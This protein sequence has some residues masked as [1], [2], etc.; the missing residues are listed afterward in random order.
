L[1]VFQESDTGLRQFGSLRNTTKQ[2][3]PDFVFQI[4]NL[5]AE[6]RLTDANTSGGAS[7]IPLFRNGKK[8][9]DVSK[10]QG[11]SPKAIKMTTIIY[12][13]NSASESTL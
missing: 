3:G 9:A 13:K 5:Q 6:R 12:W 2:R 7:E 11:P 10:F 1:D 4:S 8:I